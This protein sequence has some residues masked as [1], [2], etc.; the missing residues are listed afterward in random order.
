[1]N[2]K[3]IGEIRR[4]YTYEKN[5][6]TLIRGC[7]VNEQHEIISTFQNTLTLMPQDEAEKYLA[8]FR[9]TLSGTQGR[10]L[11]DVEFT[12]S[13]VS[14][15]E[16]HKLLSGLRSSSIKDD[17]LVDVF[18]HKIIDSLVI[19]GNYLILLAHDAYD[20]PSYTSDGKKS[21]DGSTEVFK[22]I[23]CSICPVKLT[24]PALSYYASENRFHNREIDWVVSSP[25]LGFM[26]PAFDDRKANIY[27]LLY[28]T[29]DAGNAYSEFADA[30]FHTEKP[31]V[32]AEEQRENFRSLLS[33]SLADECSYDVITAVQDQIRDMIEEHD[34]DKTDPEPLVISKGDVKAL[35]ESAGISQERIDEFDERF[36]E[37]YGSNADLVPHNIVDTRKLEVHIPEVTIK[38]NPQRS[39]LIETRVIDGIRYVLIR[40][41]GGV[42]VNG[43]P[44]NIPGTDK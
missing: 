25:E 23:L 38:V 40:A 3:E 2:K 31:I 18:F 20:M 8:I 37:Q 32:P 19:E 33:E 21:E 6:I 39:D 9:R 22:Y 34:A 24:K 12:T 7:Y 44:V 10:N 15:S 14:D 4:R 11:T 36:D 17:A 16:E 43:V 35:L 41:D 5:N 13:Q 27:N 30:I 28:Y 29:R 1:M 42:E 26:F